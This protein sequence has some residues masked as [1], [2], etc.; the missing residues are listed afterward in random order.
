[1]SW[2]FRWLDVLLS[3]LPRSRDAGDK[4]VEP[5]NAITRAIMSASFA[6][7]AA[8]VVAS[9]AAT[10]EVEVELPAAAEVVETAVEEAPETT[11]KK[12]VAA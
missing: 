3:R 9:P 12:R 11:T 2:M 6:L 1:M 4:W 7:P 10:V 8:A 5:S